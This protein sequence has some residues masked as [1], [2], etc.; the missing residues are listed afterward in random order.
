M[1]HMKEHALEAFTLLSDDRI[2]RR[3]CRRLWVTRRVAHNSTAP[4]PQREVLLKAM[5]ARPGPGLRDDNLD[6]PVLLTSGLRVIGGHRRRLPVP[7]R[8]D[9]RRVGPILEQEGPDRVGT[10]LGEIQVVGL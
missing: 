7:A 8:S 5:R 9:L 4:P 3:I 1:R 6:A 10:A 2:C